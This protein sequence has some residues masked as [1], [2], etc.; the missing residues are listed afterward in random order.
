MSREFQPMLGRFLEPSRKNS[1]L[2]SSNSLKSKNTLYFGDNLE[3]LKRHISEESVDFLEG[4]DFDFPLYGSNVSYQQAERM[5][6]AEKQ[7]EL[8]I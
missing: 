3:I 1:N 4:R 7:G 5:Q 8:E 6:D 2:L